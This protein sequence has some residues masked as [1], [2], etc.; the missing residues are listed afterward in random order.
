MHFIYIDDSTERPSGLTQAVHLGDLSLAR[1]QCLRA[2]TVDQHVDPLIGQRQVH[3]CAPPLAEQR[4]S[5]FGEW[6]M[7]AL[8]RAA[9]EALV[10]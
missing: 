2:N 5:D 4:D 10:R 6:I 8:D 3:P 1:R 7:E 9:A